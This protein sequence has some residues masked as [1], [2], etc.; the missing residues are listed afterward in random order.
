MLARKLLLLAVATFVAAARG[1]CDA[2]A[3]FLAHA[4]PLAAPVAPAVCAPLAQ[5]PPGFTWPAQKGAE[6]YTIELTFPDGHVEKQPTRWNASPW[7]AR[8]AP[9]RYTWRVSVER[10]QGTARSDSRPFTIR[11]DAAPFIVPTLDEAV[12]RADSTEHPRSWPHEP[13]KLFAALRFARATGLATL[14]TEAANHVKDAVQPEPTS[15]SKNSNYDDTVAEQKR[16]LNAALAGAATGNEVLEQDA[17]RRLMAQSRWNTSG[18]LSEAANDM[19]NRTVAWTLA[20]GYDWL[21]HDLD[22]RERQAILAA[23]RTRTQ[24]MV[25]DVLPRIARS[26]YDSHAQVS[27]TTIAAIAALVAGDVP[28]AGEWLRETLP[29]VAIWTSAWGGEDGGYANGTAQMLWDDAADLVPWYVLRNAA[30]FDLARKDWVRHH[31]RFL[32][33]FL[34]PG[35]PAG[36]FGDGAELPLGELRA[37]VAKAFDAFAPSPLL[38]W[39]AGELEGEDRSRLELLLAPLSQ[40]RQAPLPRGTPNGAFFPSVGWVAM[41]SDLADPRRTSVYFKSSPYGSHNHGHADQNAFVVNDLGKRL[42]IASGYYDDYDTAHWKDWYRQTRAANAITFDGGRGQGSGKRFSGAITRFESHP[43]YDFAIG[44]AEPA[45]GGAASLA[46]RTI[47]Y[48]R[49]DVVL[50]YDRLE[51]PVARTWEWNIHALHRMKE[52]DDTRVAIANGEA[53]LCV[54]VLASPAIAFHQTDAFTAAPRGANHPNQWHG[55]FATAAAHQRAQF[56]T[57]MRVRSDCSGENTLARH[58]AN[59]WEVRV[60]GRTVH[61]GAESVAVR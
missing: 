13:G 7:H 8:L 4:D 24:A 2:P 28:E 43:D 25:D 55:T 56:V 5:T 58:V 3:D 53:R 31:G 57:L 9:G 38:D 46:Q 45:Y 16:T 30:G 61:L 50:V 42:A 52:I 21:H 37:R 14:A 12:H 18:T 54:H 39:T 48:L 20:L 15:G 11:P 6:G 36:V 33:Y 27:L 32:A 22:A 51:A 49:P 34:P 60:N 47:V 10:A 19:A 40:P 44:R 35:S 23:L 26:P 17:I 1:A 41:H 29:L 59:G